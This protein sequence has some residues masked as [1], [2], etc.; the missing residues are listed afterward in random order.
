[1]VAAGADVLAAQTA[2]FDL[3]TTQALEPVRLLKVVVSARNPVRSFRRTMGLR[4]IVNAN[5]ARL[6][7]VAAGS[8]VLLAQAL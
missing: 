2:Q 4:N 5:A 6:G 7:V 3:L 8:S 1:M